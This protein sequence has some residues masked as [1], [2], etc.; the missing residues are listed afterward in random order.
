MTKLATMMM[1]TTIIKRRGHTRWWNDI[2]QSVPIK[3]LR[4]LKRGEGMNK[5]VL[6]LTS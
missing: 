5:M 2:G 4:K 3:P 1:T 6:M